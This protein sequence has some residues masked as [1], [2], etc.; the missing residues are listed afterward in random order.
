MFPVGIALD[1]TQP[2]LRAPG[3]AQDGDMNMDI[4]I[5]PNEKGQP[6]GKLADAEL[7]FTEGELEGLKLIGFAV[8]ERR[9]GSG[10]NVTFPSRSYSVNGERRNFALLR[11]IADAQS[12]DRVRDLI[13]EAFVA[14]QS[15]VAVAS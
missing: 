10:R 9:Q 5:I 3:V 4:K 14:W 1:R 7:H 6:A 11:P 2:A 8:W 13:L 15:Q 12:Q